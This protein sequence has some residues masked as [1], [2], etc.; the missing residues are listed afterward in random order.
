VSKAPQVEA[1]NAQTQ[2]NQ[3]TF[4]AA[5][6]Q[7]LKDAGATDD[8]LTTLT[9]IKVTSSVY[10]GGSTTTI[11]TTP[12]GDEPVGGAYRTAAS[13]LIAAAIAMLLGM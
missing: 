5:I 11:T 13:I 8:A 12:G 4:K 10:Y 7:K 3:S 1:I 9:W 6:E 2:A